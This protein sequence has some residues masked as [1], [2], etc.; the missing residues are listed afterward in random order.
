MGIT[1]LLPMVKDSIRSKH[2]KNYSG[3]K[4]GIDGHA[5]I[6]TVLPMIASELYYGKPTDRHL[7]ILLSKIRSLQDYNIIPI[8]VFDGDYLSSKEKTFVE[9]RESRE[10]A[11]QEVENCLKQKDFTRAKELMKRCVQITAGIINSI[12][13]M[14]KINKIEFFISPYEADAQ[15][16]YL[17]KIGYI[18][19]IMTED[20]D[21]IIYG[22]ENVLYKYSGSRVD[23]YDSRLLH[24]CKDKFFAQN[25]LDICILSGCDYLDSIR[26][27][28]LATAYKKLKETG[29]VENF[30]RTMQTLNKQVP[31][32]Y[33]E[34]FNN[35][36]LAFLH[37]IVYD[38]YLKRRVYL[39]E[40]EIHYDFL[41]SIDHK[42]YVVENISFD[43]HFKPDENKELSCT[44]P[45]NAKMSIFDLTPESMISPY[46]DK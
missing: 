46:F 41:G 11:R 20:S 36:K 10:K 8:F 28:G 31:E 22:A 12:I 38:P 16:Y 17:Q 18:N 25:I 2:I 29:S 24:L 39:E 34:M 27:V 45:A 5:W 26:G 33:L 30:V 1:G 21:L 9:R 6:H 13:Q 14:L 4:I 37:H 40:T 7:T 19:H 44:E 3:K 42:P 23:E 32:N 35:A 43:R 15:L